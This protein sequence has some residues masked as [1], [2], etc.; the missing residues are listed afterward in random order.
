MEDT[1]GKGPTVVSI[2]KYRSLKEDREKQEKE[3]VALKAILARAE[4]L[5]W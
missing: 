3:A 1:T 2:E 4:K 5:K